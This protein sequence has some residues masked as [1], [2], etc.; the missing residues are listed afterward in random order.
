[1][2]IPEYMTYT[3]LRDLRMHH[4]AWR[5]LRADQGPLLAAFF[6]RAFIA[7]HRRGVEA[8]ALVEALDLFLYEVSQQTGELPG[9]APQEYLELWTENG[10]LRKYAYHEAW[11]Y[12]LTVAAQKAVAWLVSLHK[13]EFVGTESRLHTVFDLLHEIARD[14]DTD[15]SH[16]VAWL[17]SE[18]QR[19]QRELDTVQKSG[20]VQPRLSEVQ[21]KER[22]LQAESTAVAILSDFR[23]VEENFRELTR[24]LRDQIVKWEQGKGEL[25]A[26]VFEASDVIRE[27][28]Q[29]RS[30]AAFWRYL[31]ASQQQEDFRATVQQVSRIQPVQ[32]L[33][34]EHPLGQMGQE[35]LQAAAAVQ[36]TL[37]QLSAQIR[38]YVNEDYLQQEKAIYQRIAAIERQA[39]ALREQQAV[40]SGGFMPMDESAPAV[41]LPMERRLFTVPQPTRLRSTV[42]EGGDASDG[43]LAPMFQQVSIDREKLRGQIRAVRGDRAEVTLKEV[44]RAYPLQQGLAELLAYFVLASQAEQAFVP[45]TLETLLFQRDG[46]QLAAL[47]ERVIYRQAEEG[48]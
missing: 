20:V 2:Q 1:M 4:P 10:W 31:M 13:R 32:E 41:M 21:V 15:V 3:F 19:L 11:Y 5:L 35:W 37:G 48:Q 33:L 39:V 23:E 29:G 24:N 43:E 46:R 28:E 22:F 17:Q 27:S 30:F 26:R 7:P 8:Q 25:L 34:P 9:R 12:D 18:I 42:L 40:P 16:R 44:L 36:Q 38:R 14:T 6:Y 47:C 45:E